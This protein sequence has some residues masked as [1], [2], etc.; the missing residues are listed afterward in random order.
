M[1]LALGIIAGLLRF[2]LGLVVGL[3]IALLL[4]PIS[5]WRH[6]R[7]VH[8][9][10]VMCDAEVTAPDMS[11]ERSP[12]LTGPAIVRLSGALAGPSAT[13]DILGFALRVVH[14]DGYTR[15]Q[16]L[17]F[18]TFDSFFTLGR[19]VKQTRPG[20]YLANRYSSVAPWW[21]EG[22]GATVLQLVP[23]G[24]GAGHSDGVG[25]GGRDARLDAEIAAGRARFDL[26]AGHRTLAQV[27]LRARRP[28]D[29][30]FR[31]SPWR[32]GRGV[33]PIGFRNGLRAIVYPINQLARRDR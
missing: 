7:V 15:D 10:G 26:I 20:D 11:G 1:R 24:D 6:R 4:A 29:P 13:S 32:T 28:D 31:M 22:Q 16:D 25:D 27:T 23:R 19:A 17:L 30:G 5:R 14:R 3:P 8:A 9:A 12:D 18:G 2:A 21:I 33:W